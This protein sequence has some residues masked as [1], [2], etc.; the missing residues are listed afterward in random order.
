MVIYNMIKLFI[1]LLLVFF[2]FNLNTINLHFLINTF[3]IPIF[4]ILYII[5]IILKS[6]FIYIYINI[7]I[8]YIFIVY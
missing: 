6:F 4:Q 2:K 3:Q 7:I 1:R 5:F 8:Y